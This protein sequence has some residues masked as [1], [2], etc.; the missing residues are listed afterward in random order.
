V[1]KFA[2]PDLIRRSAVMALGPGA[3]LTPTESAE[4]NLVDHKTKLNWSSN[5]TPYMVE[6]L[7]K[8]ASRQHREL[9]VMGP[10]RSGKSFALAEGG[11]AYILTQAPGETMFV[12]MNMAEAE[13]WS[14]VEL[15]GTLSQSPK[16]AAMRLD[17][18]GDDTVKLKR[19]DRM[20]LM[21]AWPSRGRL[22]GKTARYVIIIDGDNGTGDLSVEEVFALAQVRIR[23]YL[24]A[25]M[26]VTEGNCAKDFTDARW[27]GRTPHEAP[28]ASGMASLYNGG[29]RHCR[30]WP[31]PHCLEYFQVK[32]GLEL[33][34][35]PDLE[36]QLEMVR[37]ADLVTLADEYARI[38]C[39]HCTAE[40]RQDSREQMERRGHWVAEGQTITSDG[41]IHGDAPRNP[42][43]SYWIAGVQAAFNQ[44]HEMLLKL[45]RELRNYDSAGDC[46][47]YGHV[48][49]TE[50][51]YPHIPFAILR[52]KSK[53]NF[54]GR[55]ETWPVQTVPQGTRFLQAKVD[56][57][58][59]RFIVQVTGYGVGLESWVVD[60]YAIRH[61]HPGGTVALSP[62]SRIEDWNRLKAQVINRRY[63]L[64]DSTGRTM[65][66]VLTLIDSGGRATDRED[67]V[68]AKAYDFWRSLT[69][70]EKSRCRLV[71][72]YTRMKENVK[73]T[74][75]SGN[76]P[77]LLVNSD[78]YK[79]Q[80]ENDLKRTDNG[81][82][83]M[84][85]STALSNEYFAELTTAEIKTAKG[86]AKVKEGARNEALDLTVYGRAGCEYLKMHDPARWANPPNWALDWDKNAAVNGQPVQPNA[87]RTQLQ[88][89]V[90]SSTGIF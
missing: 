6:P 7:N 86:W 4:A 29:S 12:Q 48:L 67:S 57:Q 55:L 10:S 30:Y 44:W 43:A 17:G 45:F 24:S 3:D 50:F 40:I 47:A 66:M 28:P 59:N 61:T 49:N 42:R 41:V 9:V 65:P 19:F 26:C 68:T 1:L 37:G 11:L 71:K 63:A 46:K 23:T 27:R 20:N 84:H 76:V 78:A 33:F 25:G 38:I 22:S 5:K 35:L 2:D 39:P 87:Q 64:N 34:R 18:V 51:C 60:Y 90:R 81:P 69:P 83:K 36:A 13:T 56:V 85:F 88:R 58:G 31:C 80:I 53:H 74:I 15:E 52:Q 21:V 70:V 16:L 54:E 75:V 77:L 73:E 14:K 32:A 8:L 72:G 89:G 62:H 82:G 79:D